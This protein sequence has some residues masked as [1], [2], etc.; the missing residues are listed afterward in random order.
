MLMSTSVTIS[1]KIRLV[2]LDSLMKNYHLLMKYR[3]TNICFVN[4]TSTYGDECN[5][6]SS[7]G[8]I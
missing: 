7:V 2:T 5:N 1:Y 4:I 6:I 3:T 8:S